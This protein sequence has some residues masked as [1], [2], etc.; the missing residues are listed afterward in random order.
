VIKNILL[1]FF[2]VLLSASFCFGQMDKDAQQKLIE[3]QLVE[4]KKLDRMIGNW[5]GSGWIQQGK[6]TQ[7]FAGTETVQ[8]KLGGLAVLVEGKFVN[9][10]NVVIHETLGLLSYDLKAKNYSFDTYLANG[11]KGVH[12]LA[13]TED[14]WQWSLQFPSGTMKY[15]TK[16]IAD[17]W[18]ETGEMSMDEGKTW[19]KFFEMTLKKV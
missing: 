6:E 17:T 16:F 7:T 1:T 8:K 3:A 12:E 18:L 19:R 14:G 4:M 15:V 11:S 10:E 2:L 13:T 9:K 5:Q